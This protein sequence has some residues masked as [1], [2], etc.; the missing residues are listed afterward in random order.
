[1]ADNVAVH[2]MH[3]YT[4]IIGHGRVRQEHEFISGLEVFDHSGT[5]AEHRSV[6]GG[7]KVVGVLGP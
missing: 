4:W 7:E 3:P 1:M 2:A 6:N 5:V